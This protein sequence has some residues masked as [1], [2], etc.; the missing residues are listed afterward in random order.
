ME[1]NTYK[2]LEEIKEHGRPDFTFDIYICSIPVDF[3]EVPIHWHDDLEIISVR[4]GTGVVDLDFTPHP[5]KAGDFVVVKP[6]T[7]HAI[8]SEDPA[9]MEYENI[10]V[11]VSFFMSYHLDA[12]AQEYFIPFLEGSYPVPELYSPESWTYE[13]LIRCIGRIDSLCDRKNFAWEVGVKAALYDFFYTLFT[14]Y[15][16]AELPKKSNRKDAELKVI[17]SYVEDNYASP[18]KVAD[19]AAQLGYSESYFMRFFKEHTHKSFITYLT[20]VRLS[21]AAEA[22]RGTDSS[23]LEVAS[24]CGYDNLSLFNRQFKRKYNTTPTEYRKKLV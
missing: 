6:G 16:A 7:P 10:M 21:H 3:A 8:R 24:S 4:K 12:C 15:P 5:V 22:L 14:E 11:N 1:Q 20:E 13:P 19:A 17:L 23:V 9:G 18:L 2:A